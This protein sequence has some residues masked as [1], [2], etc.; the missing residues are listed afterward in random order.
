[1]TNRILLSEYLSNNGSSK[2]EKLSGLANVLGVVASNFYG[3]VREGK[4]EQDMYKHVYKGG[5][6]TKE[7]LDSIT[8]WK[9]YTEPVKIEE[10]GY[11][12]IY[13]KVKDK[14]DDI[15]YINIKGK[16]KES[17]VMDYH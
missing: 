13:A 16:K 8:D 14:D 3:A 2:E 7:Y 10:S 4:M 12:V 15:T 9:P 11:Y 1:M 5:T 6:L 17:M